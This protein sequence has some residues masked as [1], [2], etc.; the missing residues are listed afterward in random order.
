MGVISLT[1]I[2][3]I[4]KAEI[5]KMLL[6]DHSILL[7]KFLMEKRCNYYW[8]TIGFWNVCILQ[9]T[10]RITSLFATAVVGRK[11]GRFNFKFVG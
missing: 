5:W 7:T 11:K 2:S 8:E 1:G 6:T 4:S 3:R 10:C 9:V